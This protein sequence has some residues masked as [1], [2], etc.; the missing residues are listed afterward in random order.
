MPETTPV[1]PSHPLTPGKHTSEHRMTLVVV[2]GGFALETAMGLLSQLHQSG[3]GGDWVPKVL[4]VST[5]VL[6]ILT[7]LGYTASRAVLK[8]KALGQIDDQ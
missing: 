3:V 2:L 6:Q 7:A 4:I 1:A 5:T 8:L